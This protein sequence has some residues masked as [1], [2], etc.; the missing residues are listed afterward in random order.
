MEELTAGH[1]VERSRW[2]DGKSTSSICLAIRALTDT[3]Q[4]IIV[5]GTEARAIIGVMIC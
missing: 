3:Q 5:S 4:A 1:L 2:S